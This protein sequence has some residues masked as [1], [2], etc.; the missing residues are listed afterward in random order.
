MVL[1][2]CSQGLSYSQQVASIQDLYEMF[3]NEP[4][5]RIDALNCESWKVK[6]SGSYW[7]AAEPT[8]TNGRI[9]SEGE[10]AR[11]VQDENNDE[12]IMFYSVVAFYKSPEFEP[13]QNLRVHFRTQPGIHAG[14]MRRQ[15]FTNVLYM[16]SKTSNTGLFYQG[17]SN[18]ITCF[19]KQNAISGLMTVLG[20]I[21]AHTTVLDGTG[22]P[23]LTR[24]CYWYL[25]TRDRSG[26]QPL[27]MP[28]WMM[29]NPKWGVWYNRSVVCVSQFNYTWLYAYWANFDVFYTQ[30]TAA[31]TEED[32]DEIKEEV[33]IY[34]LKFGF[35]F[36]NQ[37][38][39]E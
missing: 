3:P 30:L 11:L 8:Q 23:Y 24:S 27:S 7:S 36:G 1:P 22:F 12:D 33:M 16:F 20:Q 17:D 19:S 5:T 10:H 35:T 34:N 28:Q 14:G 6:L 26:V 31:S 13:T 38:K 2:S 18:L 25:A 4:R 15:M 29:L 9:R 21:I 32:V 39:T 37:R